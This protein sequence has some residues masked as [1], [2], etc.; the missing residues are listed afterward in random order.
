MIRIVAHSKEYGHADVGLS[1]LIFK[2]GEVHVTVKT[3]VIAEKFTIVAHL[4]NSEEVMKLLMVTDA[5]RRAYPH[6]PV[7]LNMPY[8]PYARQDRVANA[9]EA[10]GI[11]VF[12]DLI[13]AQKYTSV[14]VQDPHSDVVGALLDNLTIDSSMGAI[15]QVVREIYEQYGQMPALVAP[16]A[17]ARKRTIQVAKALGGLEVVTADKK[18][19]TKTLEITGTIIHDALPRAPLLVVDDICDGGRTFIE[20]A[21]A[22]RA[23]E[24]VEEPPEVTPA[25][26]TRPLFLYVTHGIFSYGLDLV[27]AHFKDVYTRNNWTDD[28]RALKV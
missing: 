23:V 19:D 5:L 18:R 3:Q 26:V 24:A 7:C 12:C 25:F 1:S 10:L 15:E 16:D 22:I 27:K 9:G 2:G 21:K 4:R 11:R 20:L 14:T 8:V 6:L 13:N 28:T 17:G